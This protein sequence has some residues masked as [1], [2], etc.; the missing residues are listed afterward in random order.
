MKF[1]FTKFNTTD[2]NKG[3]IIV[4]SNPQEIFMIVEDTYGDYAALNL[5]TFVMH[6]E[7]CNHSYI[8]YLIKD[9][10]EKYVI[11]RVIKNSDLVLK[12]DARKDDW[13]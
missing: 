8:E 3:D 7:I 5:E 1:Q 10:Q 13:I 12:E 6:D 11:A 9:F 4:T 2:I